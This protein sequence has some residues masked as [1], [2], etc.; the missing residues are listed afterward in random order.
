[1]VILSRFSKS[2]QIGLGRRG[3]L[4]DRARHL[5]AAVLGD[6][7]LALSLSLV[8]SD[9]VRVHGPSLAH[10]DSFLWDS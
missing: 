5:K 8:Q 4:V 3:E 1:M 9:V 7:P 10:L 2:T 6:L